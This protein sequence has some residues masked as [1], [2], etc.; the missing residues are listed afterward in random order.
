M[1]GVVHSATAAGRAASGLPPV[2]GRRTCRS[3][4]GTVPRRVRIIARDIQLKITVFVN[5]FRRTEEVW[6][7]LSTLTANDSFI[8]L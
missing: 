5:L 4:A 8:A 7:T 2:F 1:H 3:H 6:L